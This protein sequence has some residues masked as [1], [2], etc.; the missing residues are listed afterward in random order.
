[1]SSIDISQFTP[2]GL[3]KALSSFGILEPDSIHYVESAS[4]VLTERIAFYSEY[5]NSPTI[6][7]GWVV[8]EYGYIDGDFLDDYVRFYSRCFSDYPRRCKRIHFFRHFECAEL[9]NFT[10]DTF[11]SLVLGN[12]DS[13]VLET[14]QENY[15][16]F[17]IVRPL[18]AAAIGRT[19]LK[20]YGQSA[21]PGLDRRYLSVHE[22]HVNLCGI[23]LRVV[24]LPFQE[25]DSVVSA[26]ATVA[27]WTCLGHAA[28]LYG[29]TP[30]KSATISTINSNLR[31]GRA[32]PSGGLAIEEVCSVIHDA[33]LEPEIF[34]IASDSNNLGSQ[35]WLS[36]VYAY[37]NAKLPVFLGVD[38]IENGK[39]TGLHAVALSGYTKKATGERAFLKENPL[40]AG[41][42]LI[43]LPGLRVTELYAH[44]DHAGPFSRLFT[45][46]PTSRWQKQYRLATVDPMLHKLNDKTTHFRP[47]AIVIPVYN[48]IRVNFADVCNWLTEL[49]LYLASTLTEPDLL[50]WDLV[51]TGVSELKK[52]WRKNLPNDHAKLARLLKQMPRF[53]WRATLL[54]DLEPLAEIVIDATDSAQGARVA[55]CIWYNDS[56]KTI[57]TA[58][59]IESEEAS[60]SLG[61]FLTSLLDVIRRNEGNDVH[62]NTNHI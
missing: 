61:P 59:L 38:C 3:K 29:V 7:A 46:L 23:P 33:G 60:A 49:N 15:L 20:P 26:C 54:F 22:H 44:D 1:M 5:L 45:D 14:F 27:L 17:V 11:A 4:P 35:L 28:R 8:T 42:P 21:T 55:D 52:E 58:T 10:E 34:E 16:G 24:S 51:L 32:I 31:R 36:A 43:R 19:L 6:Q 50:E 53:L 37:L 39:S 2:E 25:Q 57:I 47:K 13:E 56:L 41:S 48:K 12:F 9:K 30:P 40:L 18:P 62:A